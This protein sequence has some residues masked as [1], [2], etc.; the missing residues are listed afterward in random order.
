[1]RTCDGPEAGPCDLVC[2]GVCGLVEGADVVVNMLGYG[3]SGRQVLKL[4][5]EGRRPPGLV[6]ELNR[7]QAVAAAVDEPHLVDDRVTVVETPVTRR[8]LLDAIA[9][10]AAAPERPRPIWGDGFC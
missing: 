8:E 6:V 5:A 1:M 3:E 9:S 4:V 7:T 10:A 2:D